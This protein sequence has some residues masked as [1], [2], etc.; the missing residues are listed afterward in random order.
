AD[1]PEARLNL[2]IVKQAVGDDA[3]AR[4]AYES[5]IPAGGQ[6]AR[7]GRLNRAKLDFDAGAVDRAWAEYDALLDED[8]RDA[9]ARL[10]RALLALWLGRAAQSEMD[11]TIVLPEAPERADEILARRALARLALGR[12]EDAEGDAAGAFRRKPS[13]SRERLWIRTL[14]ALRRVQDLF[15]L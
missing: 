15:W 12:L 1:F 13:P 11:L 3:G 7:W 14:L 6:L 4:A 2:G 9:P 5:V 10:S 8:P